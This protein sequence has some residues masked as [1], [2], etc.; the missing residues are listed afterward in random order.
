MRA[1]LM[2]AVALVGGS[3]AEA[4][5]AA[6]PVQASAE[7]EP[8]FAARCRREVLA[9]N[10]QA[11]SWVAEECKQIWRR[12]Q[13]SKALVDAALALI[14]DAGAPPRDVAGVKARLPAVRWTARP[15]G[16]TLA[17]GKLGALDVAAEG[18]GRVDQVTFWWDAIGKFPPYDASQALEARGARVTMVACV[19]MGG[20]EN[21]KT[22]RVDAPGKRP[23]GMTIYDRA[24]PTA[25]GTAF[26]N[27]TVD[28]SGRAPTLASVRAAGASDAAARCPS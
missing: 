5:P 8:Q 11:A 16:E 19:A 7:T 23:F 12:V 22:Y 6:A 28:M 27:V 9:E 26:Y 18:K 14:P 4:A 3:V 13:A 24:A 25:S 2:G 17:G 1:W 20:G 10:P 21:S 15:E